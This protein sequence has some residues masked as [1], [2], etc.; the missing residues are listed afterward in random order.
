[1]TQALLN[2]KKSKNLLEAERLARLHGIKPFSMADAV[3]DP[4]ITD[5]ELEDFLKWR[6]EVRAAD[7]EAQRN[8]LP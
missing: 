3:Q 2:N 4:T 8:C 5:E 1:M 7:V 6:R